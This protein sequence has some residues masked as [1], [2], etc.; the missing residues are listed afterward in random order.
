MP[1][2]FR[3]SSEHETSRRAALIAEEGESV[4]LYLTEPGGG[5]IVADCW[6]FNRVPAPSGEE[7]RARR[8]EFRE[9]GVPPPASQEVI[10]QAALLGGPLDESR[11]SFVWSAD[12]E[13]VAAWL[14]GQL[15]GFIAPGESRGYSAHLRTRSPWGQPLLVERYDQLFA[16]GPSAA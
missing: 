5:Q 10:D 8:A 9:R 6:L 12:G 7:V 2:Q 15:A 1:R 11:A 3:I 16:S 4:W 13:A 14:D